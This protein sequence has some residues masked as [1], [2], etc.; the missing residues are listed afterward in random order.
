MQAGYAIL[1]VEQKSAWLLDL[2]E[3]EDGGGE[4]QGL[5]SCSYSVHEVTDSAVPAPWPL[6]FPQVKGRLGGPKWGL[7]SPR[8]LSGRA[9]LLASREER[10]AEA[11]EAGKEGGVE[12]RIPPVI[13]REQRGARE[14]RSSPR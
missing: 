13:K 3:D 5:V 11:R 2:E 6:R 14:E 9:R 4:Q 7:Y 10:G 1:I 12:L 8:E